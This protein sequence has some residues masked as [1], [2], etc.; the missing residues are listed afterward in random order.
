MCCST[1]SSA[2]ARNGTEGAD[3]FR[4]RD[5]T[6]SLTD[7]CSSGVSALITSARFSTVIAAFRSQ[8]TAALSGPAWPISSEQPISPRWPRCTYNGQKRLARLSIFVFGA[9]A[10]VVIAAQTAPF[11]RPFTRYSRR[12]SATSTAL[13]DGVA[14]ATRLQF[15]EPGAAAE[16]IEAFGK[17]LVV[18]VDVRNAANSLLLRKPTARVARRRAAHP[19]RQSARGGAAGVD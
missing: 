12:R 16:Q 5:S 18:L 8:Y 11:R 17:S 2:A 6:N 10:A 19:A 1:N 4:F 7:S 15:P 14:S 3:P 9:F 13:I